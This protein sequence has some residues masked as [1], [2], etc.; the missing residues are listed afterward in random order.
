MT[1]MG[2]GKVVRVG[3]EVGLEWMSVGSWEG[4]EE[5]AAMV[6]GAIFS[7]SFSAIFAALGLLRFLIQFCS[8][9]T[10]DNTSSTVDWLV[11]FP[12]PD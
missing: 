4:R 6:Y 2:C 5:V 3:R 9:E 11:L 12:K 7:A 1:T 8:R 10:G